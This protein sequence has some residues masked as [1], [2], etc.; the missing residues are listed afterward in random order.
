MENSLP[1]Q[2][3]SSEFVFIWSL[4][5]PLSVASVANEETAGHCTL[6]SAPSSTIV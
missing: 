3:G 2:V 6:Q 1:V 5:R 4:R